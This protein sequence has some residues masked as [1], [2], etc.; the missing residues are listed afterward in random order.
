M[1]R[2]NF[3][4]DLHECK[5]CQ[6]FWEK[7]IETLPVSECEEFH[8]HVIEAHPGLQRP[9]PGVD[10]ANGQKGTPAPE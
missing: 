6:D 8:K 10:G 4:L 9:E 3:Y 7:E 1:S 2:T 5:V